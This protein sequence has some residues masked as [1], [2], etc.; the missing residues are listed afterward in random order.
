MPSARKEHSALRM[1][2]RVDG[3]VFLEGVT[4][5][6][7][8]AVTHLHAILAAVAAARHTGST[9]MNAQSSR[10]HVLVLFRLRLTDRQGQVADVQLTFVGRCPM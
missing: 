7:C 9:A 5:Q 1:R 4:W 2:E 3:T 10:S 8:P 6:G